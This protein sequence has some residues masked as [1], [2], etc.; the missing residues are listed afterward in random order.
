M[1][2]HLSN[3]CHDNEVGDLVINLTIGNLTKFRETS[4]QLG[5]ALPLGMIII[6]LFHAQQD[7]KTPGNA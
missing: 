1:L 4:I 6:H 5:G 7:F 3:N 2:G